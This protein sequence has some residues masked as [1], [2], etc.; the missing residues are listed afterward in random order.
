MALDNALFLVDRGG[1]NYRSKGSDIG[2]RMKSGDR[3]LVQRGTNH[4]KATY[5]GSG[6]DKIRDSDLLLAWDGT[7]NRKVTGENFKALFGRTCYLKELQQHSAYDGQY[8]PS[9]K[10]AADEVNGYL[11]FAPDSEFA[12]N[13]SVGQQ[14]EVQEKGKDERYLLTPHRVEFSNYGQ[15]RWLVDVGKEG[16]PFYAYR[17]GT[18]TFDTCPRRARLTWNWRGHSSDSNAY[19]MCNNSR[20]GTGVHYTGWGSTYLSNV[21]ANGATNSWLTVLYDYQ[22]KFQYNDREQW[23]KFG[24][25]PAVE[26]FNDTYFSGSDCSF[27]PLGY[28]DIGQPFTQSGV[29]VTYHNHNPDYCRKE[30]YEQNGGGNC[31]PAGKIKIAWQ[32]TQARTVIRVPGADWADVL[33]DGAYIWLNGNPYKMTNPVKNECGGDPDYTRIYIQERVEGNTETAGTMWTVTNCPP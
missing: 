5:D 8:P 4:F 1:T 31:P 28:P 13:L 11:F 29:K 21:D 27:T 24:D 3:V 12:K 26:H 7:N 19:K 10:F 17:S 16:F 25:A 23:Y 30:T 15:A 14:F 9:G 22:N 33:E 32:D 20:T 6:W 18:W 2:E